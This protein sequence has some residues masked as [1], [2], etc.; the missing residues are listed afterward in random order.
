MPLLSMVQTRYT[1]LGLCLRTCVGFRPRSDG[2]AEAISTE[3]NAEHQTFF[4]D[5]HALNSPEPRRSRNFSH[6]MGVLEEHTNDRHHGQAL[7]A[8]AQRIVRTTWG[9]EFYGIL[10]KA[11]KSA[12]VSRLL[13]GPSGI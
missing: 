6:P 3:P 5:P 10:S 4:R 7:A 13:R 8:A 12:G 9:S 1:S 11:L 2:A